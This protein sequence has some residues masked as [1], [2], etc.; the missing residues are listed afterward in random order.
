[1]EPSQA[2]ESFGDSQQQIGIIT[3]AAV[4]QA[5]EGVDPTDESSLSHLQTL[6]V[7]LIQSWG[8]VASVRAMDYYQSERALQ[9]IAGRLHVPLAPVTDLATIRRDIAWAI[10]P[11]QAGGDLGTVIDVT[12]GSAERHILNA[13]RNTITD[14]VNRDG[15]AK[16]W[17]RGLEPGFC[18]F[19]SLLA[20]RG[21]VYKE[22]SFTRSNA[23][24]HGTVGQIKVHDN[25]Q[26]YPVPVFD[27]YEA[28]ARI[29]EMQA[30]Y[31]KVTE[32][33]SG[34]D[35]IRAW[36]AHME[37]KAGQVGPTA[38]EARLIPAPPEP[39]VYDPA[40]VAAT[41]KKLEAAIASQVA[42]GHGDKPWVRAMRDTLAA[43]QSAA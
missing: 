29:Q 15:R 31:R 35:K 34:K 8:R 30:E 2:S 32:H 20:M 7:A 23:R 40:R 21:A 9:G 24:F 38:R 14:A 39:R 10:R 12:A 25:C 1:M 16:G 6:L 27:R 19:C 28:P 33:L 42:V 41:A 4:R 5:F 3:A 22:N 13:G 18:Y 37:R 17:A 43:L 11:L 26:C 36:R